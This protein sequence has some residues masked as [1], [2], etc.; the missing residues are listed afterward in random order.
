MRFL[1]FYGR[2][3][4]MLFLGT[5]LVKVLVVLDAAPVPAP[6]PAPA[7][8]CADDGITP[9]DDRTG[10]RADVGAFAIEEG[11]F[12]CDVPGAGNVRVLKRVDVDGGSVGVVGPF[13]TTRDGAAVKRGSII[14]FDR[15]V[16]IGIVVAD[17]LHFADWIFVAV[18]LTKDL[19]DFICDISMNNHFAAVIASVKAPIGHPKIAQIGQRNRTATVPGVAAKHAGFNLRSDGA[20]MGSVSCD[21]KPGKGEKEGDFF[22]GCIVAKKD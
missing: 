21:E 19:G 16:V 18:E 10:V 12:V 22:H 1:L 15:S 20:D 17:Q 14:C 11:S 2:S 3:V 6:S 5:G 8:E 7:F 9:D 4:D 13:G